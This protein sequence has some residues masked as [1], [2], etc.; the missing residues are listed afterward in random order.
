M[1]IKSKLDDLYSLV[2][3]R[4]EPL[5]SDVIK[6]LSLTLKE[7]N[8]SKLIIIKFKNE[9]G[10][11]L[12]RSI[13]TAFSDAEWQ[14]N[15]GMEHGEFPANINIGAPAP[16]TETEEIKRAIE[17]VAALKVGIDTGNL[18]YRGSAITILIGLRLN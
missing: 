12:A 2:G 10:R 11:E 3:S 13:A 4:W 17:N 15:C 7:I 14:V 18:A 1:E 5:T 9:L 16:Y 6:K 8:S